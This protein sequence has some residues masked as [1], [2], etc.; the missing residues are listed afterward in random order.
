MS[1]SLYTY[2]KHYDVIVCGAGH[3]GVEAAMAAARLGCQTAILTQNLDTISQMSCN[4]AIGGLAK[5]HVVREI[6]AL[7]GVMGRNTDA[8]GIQFRMLNA[9][10]GPSVQA[11]R[12]QCDKKAYQFRM[13]WLI[14]NQPNLDLHQG[15]AAELLVE[16][17]AIIG[18]RTS[19]G[20]IYRA[21]AIII[22]SGTFMRG[23]L[24]VGQQNQAGG[25]MG[26]SISTLSDSLRHLGFDV[27][28]FKTGT[29]CRLNSRSIDF[30]KC[31]LQPG[32]EPA[33]R[34]SYLSGVLPE[35]EDETFSQ[36]PSLPVS[37]SQSLPTTGPNQFTLNSWS[38][39][40]FHVEQ[41]PCWI[42]YTTPQ[43]HDII[44][45]N[46]HK[47][48]MY[49]GK[50]EG[51]G[52]RYCPSVEDKVVRFAEKDRHQ[53][54]LE[55]EGRHTR[56]F[57]VNGVS[58]SLPFEVQYEFIRSIPGLENAEIVRPGYAVEY[59]Y[60][61]PTQLHPTLETKRI[62]GLYF[63]GQINGTSGYEEAAGQGL[64]A[65]ANA[66]LKATGRPPFLLQRSQAYLAVMI[67]DLVTKGTTEPYRL[68]TSRAEYRLLLRQ[69]NCD[70]RLTPL[71]AAIGLAS[72]FRVR[73]T[74][75][76]IAQ[77]AAA[78]VLLQ[79]ARLD[80]IT[81]E[82]W[83]RRPENT[84]TTLPAEIHAQFTPEVWSLV[85]N[86]VKY[87][88]YITRQEDMVAKT[89]RME[90]KM[91]PADFDYHAIPGLKTEAKHRLTALRPATLGQAARAQGVNPADIALLAVM[92][93]R[94][95]GE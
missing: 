42:T 24:H 60:C 52:P 29:P 95:G 91:I 71:V 49:S 45:A 59:D 72:P 55:P 28:R 44:R 12:A 57:Y 21:K 19:L 26:D 76:K 7:G 5:G 88:G 86:D 53:I 20:M 74:E 34:F 10:K 77:L 18:V 31:E 87:A 66:A 78:R 4:P 58:T 13:K 81:L 17:D 11:P 50:I 36:S 56:E 79:Q 64:I 75:E 40:K 35:D 15:N 37:P 43:T 80:G 62:A 8:T 61:P 93:K 14:E 48:A 85:E 89:S 22:S 94:G 33:P 32:D 54:F 41:I 69:D 73:H 16:N 3:A 46:I 39:E 92:L 38:P 90:E 82:K 6:D 25:R 84:P 51:V 67:D 23:L 9:R 70:L 63:A 1:E 68:F 47:S 2:P 30:S 83:L 65:G 27:Q